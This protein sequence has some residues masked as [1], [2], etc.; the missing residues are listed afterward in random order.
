MGCISL[1]IRVE[2]IEQLPRGRFSGEIMN[3]CSGALGMQGLLKWDH[4]MDAWIAALGAK[5]L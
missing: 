5:G 1:G 3:A 4:C 2:G